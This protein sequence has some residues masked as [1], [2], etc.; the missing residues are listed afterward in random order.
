MID[1]LTITLGRELYLKRLINSFVDDSGYK[2]FNFN[3]YIVYQGNPTREFLDFMDTTPIKGNVRLIVNDQRVQSVGV[4]M[5]EFKN[6]VSNK[7]FWKLDD[8]ALLRSRNALHHIRAINELKPQAVFS[9]YPVGLINNPGGVLS[10]EHSVAYSESTDT[11]YTFRKVLHVGGFARIMPIEF[12]KQMVFSDSHSE[13]TECSSWCNN[14]GKH[15]YYL[16]NGLIV[17]HQESTLGQHAR[18]GKT[19][20]RDRF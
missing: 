15:M 10:K 2:D 5:N 17:E 12:F 19:Y 14:N 3:Y 11:Y 13:D 6:K 7:L 9:P 4:V 18:Y 1:I 20:F 8:D 16:E